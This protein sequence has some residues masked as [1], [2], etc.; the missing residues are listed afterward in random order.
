MYPLVAIMACESARRT[1]DYIQHGC[2][3]FETKNP[4]SR[5][6]SFWLEE[7]VW[8]YLKQNNVPYSSIYNLGYERTGC[9]FCLF[10]VH[11]EKEN[12]S[13]RSDETI[14]WKNQG[15]LKN[16]TKPFNLFLKKR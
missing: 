8:N 3:V 4:I 9:M 16:T 10:G 1:K 13:I 12:R 5:P 2:S 14:I 15:C 11:M 6:M 7:D